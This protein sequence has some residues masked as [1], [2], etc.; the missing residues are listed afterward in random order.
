M[1]EFV[2]PSPSFA[3]PPDMLAAYVRGQMSN[4]A[5]PAA[6]Q[7][8]QA[9]QQDLQEGSLKIDQLRL[10]LQ[11]Q[12]MYQQ[13]AQES[14]GQQGSQSAGA[15]S[16]AVPTG[17]VQGQQSA[18]QE[19]I[20]GFQPTTLAA[21][22][23][24][25]GDDPL[26]T[27]QGVQEYQLKQR[28]LQA[29]G[30]LNLAETVASSPQ[31]DV[32]I[33]NN[34]SLQQQWIKAA[35]QLGL[36]PF[37]DLNPQNARM[38]ATMLYNQVAGAAGMPAKP[39]PVQEEQI[40]GPNGQRLSRNSLTGE[41]KQEVPEESLHQVIGANGQPQLLP[42]S[43]AAGKT[44]FN[45]SIFGAASLSDQ[46]L[47][48]AADTYRT[49]GK[50]P[51][52]FGR[53]PAMQARVLDK[54]ASDAAAAG[55]TA[56]SIA[57]RAAGLKANGQAL[58]QVTKLESATTSYYN[59]LDKNLDALKELGTKVDSTGSPLINKVY[60]AWQQG[61]SG[62]PATAQYV[63]ML[64]SVETEFAKIQ[65]GSLGNAPLSD[66]SR[67]ESRDIINKY[68]SQGQIDAVAQTMR[69][70]GGN[71][72][73]AIRDQKQ[74]LMGSLGSSAPATHGA[75]PASAPSAPGAHPAAVQALLDK[76]K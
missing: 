19:G 35:P 45:Q 76:Y 69:Q 5:V 73:A 41:I 12:R 26:K 42:A 65:S 6:Q 44:P 25:R 38:V 74:S 68:M 63:T 7:Q 61:V 50:M 34:P 43:Q 13:Y 23:I 14:I 56:G 28:Q 70:E 67:K 15:Q 20:S 17:G 52:Q 39:M 53:S 54:V 49:T 18:P 3:P 27:A 66:A 30:P 24:L 47:Q 40:K 9:G 48:L 64:K 51:A 29:Q 22:A 1:A 32:I 62:D 10:A 11:N 2:A 33:K 60:R 8:M 31:A 71:R 72:L 58:D 37:K 57:A 21:L 75:T 55:D 59:T 16:A 36:D 4:F 46:A